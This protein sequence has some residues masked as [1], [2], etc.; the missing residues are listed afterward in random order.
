M[1]VDDPA[2][3]FAPAV[4]GLAAVHGEHHR[5]GVDRLLRHS[6]CTGCCCEAS[7]PL[8]GSAFACPFGDQPL[9]PLL[10]QAQRDQ[11]GELAGRDR[12]H[13]GTEVRDEP[14]DVRPDPVVDLTYLEDRRGAGPFGRMQL[15]SELQPEALG[16]GDDPFDDRLVGADLDPDDAEPQP[17]RRVELAFQGRDHLVV[18]EQPVAALGHVDVRAEAGRH[19]VVLRDHPLP[20][21]DELVRGVGE[22]RDGLEA[23][24]LHAGTESTFGHRRQQALEVVGSGHPLVRG[25]VQRDAGLHRVTSKV[26]S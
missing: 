14:E 7:E 12:T 22:G 19:E 1:H 15:H 6:G 21:A 18:A 24:D 23:D 9:H 26:S 2:R 3:Q 4:D 8:E 16:G 20:V 11:V 13:G 5:R 25:R 17:G 10:R